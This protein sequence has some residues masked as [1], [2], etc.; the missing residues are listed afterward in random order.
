MSGA[1]NRDSFVQRIPLQIPDLRGREADYLAECVETNWVSSA[2]P[3]VTRLEDAVASLAGRRNAVAVVNGTAALHLSLVGLGIGEGD[4]VIVPD[5]TFAATANAV[6]H[7][8]A[9][10]VFVDVCESDWMIDPGIVEVAIEKHDA[11]GVIAVD[12]LGACADFDQLAGLCR[13]ADIKL[14]EDAACSIGATRGGL[15]A[16][17]F[18]DCATFSFNGNKTVTAGGGGAIVTDNDDLAES[19]RHLS[20]Q[21]RVGDRY[22]HDAAGWNYRMTNLNAAV[23]VA[24]LERLNDMMQ[25][26]RQIA[27]VYDR[28]IEGREDLRV[29]PRPLD[30]CYNIWLYSVLCAS[31]EDAQKL[32]AHLANAQIE[33]RL[34]WESLSYQAPYREYPNILKGVSR[35]LSGRVVSLPS[36]SNLDDASM[37]RIKETLASWR[38]NWFGQVSVG[39]VADTSE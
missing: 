8:G 19:F 10:P 26:K 37:D 4:R 5:W 17:S 16:G 27:A 25:R 2:G 30:C 1:E 32:V 24:Q 18:G 14:V 31:R 38:G 35:S 11:R 23:G 29:M 28:V 3:F 20:T 21:A 6:I 36:S 9:V 12:T 7:A 15:A 22:S 33:A 13:S 34:F 39:R